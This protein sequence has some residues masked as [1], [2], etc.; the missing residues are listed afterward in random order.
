MGGLA[1]MA[2]VGKC[3]AF[4]AKWSMTGIISPKVNGVRGGQ[5]QAGG[6][7]R[8]TDSY[9]PL[10]PSSPSYPPCRCNG[11]YEYTRRCERSGPEEAATTTTLLIRLR[12]GSWE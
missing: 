8:G 7:Y 11:A 12:E 5:R 4:G 6:R 9:G 1:V 3:M 10:G 2:L